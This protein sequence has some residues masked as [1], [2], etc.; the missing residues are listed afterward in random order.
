MCTVYGCSDLVTVDGR[1]M[2]H[3]E[4]HRLGLAHHHGPVFVPEPVKLP[5]PPV[6]ATATDHHHYGTGPAGVSV[7]GM[8]QARLIEVEASVLAKNDAIAMANR[9][10][11]SVMSP[12][13]TARC[14][15][16]TQDLK[17]HAPR[18]WRIKAVRAGDQIV[19]IVE[20]KL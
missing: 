1:E 7:P 18:T 10:V 11:L 17:I 12:P 20:R 16:Q 9:R 4:A 14:A 3:D 19:E 15:K 13:R 8:S 2:T 5:F 6:H